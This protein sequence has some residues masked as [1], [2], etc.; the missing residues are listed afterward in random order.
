[1]TATLDLRVPL[2]E[3]LITNGEFTGSATGWTLN[4]GW[5]YGGN[6]VSHT[7]GSTG[8]LEPTTP[9]TIEIGKM[10]H[11]VVD[12]EVTAG[13]VDASFGSRTVEI[14]ETDVWER[15]WIAQTTDSLVFTPTTSAFDGAIT[16]VTIREITPA[17]SVSHDGLSG[18]VVS[19]L[20]QVR[21]NRTTDSEHYLDVNG[22][23]HVE[24]DISTAGSILAE[25]GDVL[26]SSVQTD[27]GISAFGIKP[28]VSFEPIPFANAPDPSDRAIFVVIDDSLTSTKGDVISGGGANLV[29]GMSNGTDWIVV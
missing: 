13:S 29:L 21:I 5:S 6:K 4:T 7:P 1:M 24:G 12:A 27:R 8:T 18:L 19:A 15:L 28:T 9:V 11:F 22:S 26:C 25:N 23:C 2:G 17:L 16:R 20:G 14:T 10:Y 3:E